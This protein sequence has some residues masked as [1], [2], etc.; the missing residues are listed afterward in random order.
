MKAQSK[1]DH[2][3]RTIICKKDNASIRKQT[4]TVRAAL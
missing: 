1:D 4:S 2:P 3:E